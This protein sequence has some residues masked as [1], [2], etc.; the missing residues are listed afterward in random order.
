MSEQQEMKI[1]D[2]NITKIGFIKCVDC[3]DYVICPHVGIREGC[4]TK[5]KVKEVYSNE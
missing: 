3:E 1:R 5:E 4:R 2:S